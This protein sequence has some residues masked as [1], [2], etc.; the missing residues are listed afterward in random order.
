MS[1]TPNTHTHTH[2]P[3]G[4]QH[5]PKVK[6]QPSRLTSVQGGGGVMRLD[7]L[8]ADCMWCAGCNTSLMA[9]YTPFTLLLAQA[10]AVL[11]VCGPRGAS[12]LPR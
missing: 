2:T 9:M 3:Y 10:A 1:R 7:D 8:Q 11:A 12:V 6:Q 5:P 4:S